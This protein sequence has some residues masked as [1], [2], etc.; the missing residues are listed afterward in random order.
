MVNYHYHFPIFKCFYF[1]KSSFKNHR[2]C[3]FHWHGYFES[4]MS[5]Y[6]IVKRN[7]VCVCV[8]KFRYFTHGKVPNITCFY[9]IITVE[10]HVHWKVS[11]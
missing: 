9:S 6:T 10:L 8:F 5:Y 3:S 2:V 11:P 7:I 1:G 4:S